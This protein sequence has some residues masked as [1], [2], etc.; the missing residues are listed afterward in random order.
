MVQLRSVYK[1]M[2]FIA[3]YNFCIGISNPA[4]DN[5]LLLGLGFTNWKM[6]IIT[7]VGSIFAWFGVQLYRCFLC[8]YSWRMIYV[9]TTL[10]VVSFSVLQI[11]LIFQ[12]NHRLGISDLAFSIGDDS[13]TYVAKEDFFLS[14]VTPHLTIPSLV[15]EGMVARH[16]HLALLPSG[17]WHCCIA[18]VQVLH[19]GDPVPAFCQD[20]PPALP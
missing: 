16:L 13:I 1:P 6:G 10:L 18:D 2:A 5:F 8:N 15:Y 14:V 17:V 4:W 12:V 7:I 19:R 11:L 9:V 3:V 20:V